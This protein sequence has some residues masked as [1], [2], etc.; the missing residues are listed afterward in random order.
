MAMA[1]A[2]ALAPRLIRG[3]LG[4]VAGVVEAVPP[5]LTAR[6]TEEDPLPRPPLDRRPRPRPR[7]GGIGNA[8]SS[9]EEEFT[10]GYLKF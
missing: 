4:C 6:S 2:T 8:V 9:E 3:A 1:F 10:F 7:V 5:A